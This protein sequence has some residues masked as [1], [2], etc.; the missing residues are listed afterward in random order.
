MRFIWTPPSGRSTR[1]AAHSIVLLRTACVAG[2]THALEIATTNP[3]DVASESAP[4]LP[5][6]QHHARSLRRIGEPILN[7]SFQCIQAREHGE[8]ERREIVSSRFTIQRRI[9][10]PT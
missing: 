4:A 5:V 9:C 8:P 3:Y 1:H 6:V 7:A 10:S 2:A